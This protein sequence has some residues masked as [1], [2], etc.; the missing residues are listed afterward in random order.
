MS[1]DLLLLRDGPVA[2]VVINRPE[3]RN[4]ISHAMWLALP[5]LL[6]E[7]AR[8]DAVRVVVLAGAG[9]KAFSAGADIKDFEETRGTPERARNYRGTVDAACE[10]LGALPKPTI[11]SIRGYCLGGGFELAL[12]AD[13]R[14]ASSDAQFGLPAAKRGIVISHTHV[15]RAMKLAGAGAAGYLLISGRN[16]SAQQALAAGLLSSVVKPDALSDET[17]A[18]AGE[19]AELSPVSHRFHKGVVRD[20]IEFG[21][22]PQVPQ[23]RRDALR[24]TEASEDFLEG[25]RSFK[26]KRKPNFPGR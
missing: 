23:E 10:A 9:D 18:L 11:A 21:A 1:D 24:S 2:T 16:I 20:L 8:D 5:G 12:Y 25:V 7:A 26:E 4:A 3:Q 17:A 22:A 14:I 6:D 13:I 15:D 19:I